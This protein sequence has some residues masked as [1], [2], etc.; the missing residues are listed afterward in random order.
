MRL[1]D[2]E[3]AANTSFELA[4]SSPKKKTLKLIRGRQAGPFCLEC[5]PPLNYWFLIQTLKNRCVSAITSIK[6]STSTLVL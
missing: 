6:R 5:W 2:A 3:T 1:A 4:K